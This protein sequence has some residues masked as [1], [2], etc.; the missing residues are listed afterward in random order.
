MVLILSEILKFKFLNKDT[1]VKIQKNNNKRKCKIFVSIYH[2][3]ACLCIIFV[4][5]TSYLCR[6]FSNA[7]ISF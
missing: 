7:K 1:R 4:K 2:K 3:A 6:Q 5:S